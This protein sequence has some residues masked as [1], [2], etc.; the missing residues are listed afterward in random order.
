MDESE[1]TDDE[2]ERVAATMTFAAVFSV[3]MVVLAALYGAVQWW[4]AGNGFAFILFVATLFGVAMVYFGTE[5][6]LGN[7]LAEPR[8]VIYIGLVAGILFTWLQWVACLACETGSAAVL[9]PTDLLSSLEAYRTKANYEVW[10]IRTDASPGP[11]MRT[12]VW[13]GEALVTLIFVPWIAVWLR[14]LH[15]DLSDG[16]EELEA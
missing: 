16:I 12:A 11:G 2:P 1:N 6:L 3:G 14:D 15:D 5:S 4:V 7:L 9:V 8:V 13:L 10:A